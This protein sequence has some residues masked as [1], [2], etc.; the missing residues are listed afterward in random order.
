MATHAARTTMNGK[1]RQARLNGPGLNLSLSLNSNYLE[2]I[3]RGHTISG[4]A[5]RRR[6]QES[7]LKRLNDWVL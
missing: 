1:P 5:A 2:W 7:D 6:T 3:P 4:A